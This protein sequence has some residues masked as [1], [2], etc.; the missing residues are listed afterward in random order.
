MAK[1]KETAAET[2]E[3]KPATAAPTFTKDRLAKSKRYR[4]K[5]DLINALL[6]EGKEYTLDEVDARIEEFMNME[7]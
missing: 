6:E 4:E 2:V 5:V 1:I 7:V 3:E